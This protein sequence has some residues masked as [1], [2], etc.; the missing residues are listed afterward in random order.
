MFGRPV[1]MADLAG[2]LLS[3]SKQAMGRFPALRFSI[4]DAQAMPPA[5]TAKR[6]DL[7]SDTGQNCVEVGEMSSNRNG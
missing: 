1:T 6:I 5:G 3:R 2:T 7:S 4:K